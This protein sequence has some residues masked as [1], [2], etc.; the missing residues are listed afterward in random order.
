MATT[1]PKLLHVFSTLAV[2]GPQARTAE[3]IRAFGTAFE[4]A[5][6]A[7]DGRTEAV[8]AFDLAHTVRLLPLRFDK[9]RGIAPR[10]L[11]EIRR[12][13]RAERPALLLTYNF[14][15]IEA[16]LANRLRPLCPHLHF[17]DGFGPEESADAQ[18]RRRVWLRRLALRSDTRIVVPSRTLER[19]AVERWGFPAGRVLFI[20][21]SVDLARF[22]APR[23]APAAGIERRPGE[24]LIGTLAAL[25]PEK[26]LARL[27]RAFAAASQRLPSR[28]AIVGDGPERQ[29]L[30]ALAGEL[31]IAERVIFTGQLARPE[32][33]LAMLDLFALSS[34]TEQMPI[35]L[36]EAMAAG[37]PVVATDVGDIAAVL[38]PAQRPFV[39]KL[40]AEDRLAPALARLMTDGVLRRRLGAANQAQARR[41]FDRNAMIARY[42]EL[43]AASLA[44]ARPSSRPGPSRPDTVPTC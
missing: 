30:H 7:V 41:L 26:N 39:V 43:F 20:A 3:L 2:G 11:I 25:R 42:R 4:H 23:S 10:N 1:A 9:G 34:D 35:S 15:A 18:L 40:A 13:L 31:G 12:L 5:L 37:L 17:E 33:V 44:A 8:A 19:L 24:V 38:P 22:A 6:V 14:G 27:L 36:L 28:L 29:R 32:D 21:N 16:A